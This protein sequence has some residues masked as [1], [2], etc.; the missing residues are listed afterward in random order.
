MVGINTIESAPEQSKACSVPVIGKHY[1]RRGGGLEILSFSLQITV[2]N[3]INL[4]RWE[5]TWWQNKI[6]SYHTKL[7]YLLIA[8]Q[9][10]YHHKATSQ[11]CE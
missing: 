7:F 10:Q 5:Q 2:D 11:L 3:A 6:N 9:L 8:N 4:F 1:R